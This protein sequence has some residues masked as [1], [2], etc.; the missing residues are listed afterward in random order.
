MYRTNPSGLLL[1]LGHYNWFVSYFQYVGF[2]LDLKLQ[3]LRLAKKSQTLTSGNSPIYPFFPWIL[4]NAYWDLMSLPPHLY[5]SIWGVQSD[6]TFSMNATYSSQLK[7]L[8]VL[9]LIHDDNSFSR[10]QLSCWDEKNALKFAFAL[11]LSLKH[12][13]KNCRIC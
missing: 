8:C 1:S 11:L 10:E 7:W 6:P 2:H 12:W 4:K 5:S 3:P 9:Q 13:K